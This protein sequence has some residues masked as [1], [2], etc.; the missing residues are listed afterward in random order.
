[1]FCSFC[2][3]Q[4]NDVLDVLIE[5][6]VEVEQNENFIRFKPLILNRSPLYFEYNYLLL[7]RKTDKN[8][9]LSVEYNRGRFTLTPEEVKALPSL[10]YAKT[11]D[12]D[13]IKVNLYIRDEAENVLIAKDSA[14]VTN[15]I[16]NKRKRLDERSVAIRGIVVDETKTK[17]GSD[18]YSDFYSIYNQMP[19]KLDFVLS[20]SEL[21]YR[22]MTSIIQIKADQD[23]IYEFFTNPNEEYIQ[24]QAKQTIRAI[25]QYIRN[26]E[27][28]KYEFNY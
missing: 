21:P 27:T 9:Q 3:S 4:E 11:P 1:M 15:V 8:N 2:Y 20:I 7:I 6:S 14:E 22:G 19:S 10:E 16:S 28:I 17:V 18:F 23:V 25:G 24:Q 13:K 5:A 12:I 26:K